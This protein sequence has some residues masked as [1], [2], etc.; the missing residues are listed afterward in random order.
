MLILLH[1]GMNRWRICSEQFTRLPESIRLRPFQ[2][3]ERVRN[4]RLLYIAL[5]RF[6]AEFI[7]IRFQ[8]VNVLL[9]R[10]RRR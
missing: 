9:I 8:W 4:M 3:V 5:F 2:S 7:V 10:A 6:R 1:S